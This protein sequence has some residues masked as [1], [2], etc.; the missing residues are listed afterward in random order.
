[1]VMRGL[2]R[3][4]GEYPRLGRHVPPKL[5][6]MKPF[7]FFSDAQLCL[8]A[9]RVFQSLAC[10]Q[11]VSV[12][13]MLELYVPCVS[14]LFGG[15]CPVQGQ[16]ER[17]MKT[18][19]LLSNGWI[20]AGL[21][22]LYLGGGP[23]RAD[24]VGSI[25]LTGHDPDFHA[26]LG[27]NALGAQ[28]IN[29]AAINFIMDP[30]FNTFVAGGTKEFLFVEC[31]TC[32]VPG[33]HTDGV[34]GINDSASGFPAGTTFETHGAADGL[35]TELT[36]LG[37]KY[38]AIVIGSDFG[39]MLTQAE[40]DLLNADQSGIISFLN[41]GGG[42]Y[43]MSEGSGC[44]ALTSHDRWGFLPFVTTEDPKDQGESGFTVTSFGAGL[45]LA[46]GDVNGNAS[47]SVFTGTFGL[48]IVDTDPSG[49][50]LSLAG[51]GKVSTGGVV[52]EPGSVLLFGTS[53]LLLAG[54]FA[55]RKRT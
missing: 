28:H 53:L 31:D 3:F 35:A 2:P 4:G 55:F 18:R 47:H 5:W 22:A 42:L 33:G 23:A 21:F 10:I 29:Q 25:F 38:S 20:C 39:G 19:A 13:S 44:C 43:G 40:L 34:P 49:D 51:R 30:A 32:P 17:V 36:K 50:I 9:A 15:V 46:D 16:E 6:D 8:R 54:R 7:C 14:D 27:G 12:H 48:N 41:A 11:W 52:P 37:T 26:A 1:M 45:G 24:I